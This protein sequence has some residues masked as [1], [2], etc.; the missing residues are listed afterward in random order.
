[1]RRDGWES[2]SPIRTDGELPANGEPAIFKHSDLS[3]QTGA[4]GERR[5][6]RRLPEAA[7]MVLFLLLVI[8]AITLGILGVCPQ[9][10]FYLVIIGVIVLMPTLS[11]S[12]HGSAEAAA[13][14]PLTSPDP[15]R[16][17]TSDGRP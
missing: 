12:V 6:A 8:A 7:E 10:P 1:M 17:V 5:L 11:T 16:P 3:Y 4:G 14:R 13:S 9:V 15:Y 2:A